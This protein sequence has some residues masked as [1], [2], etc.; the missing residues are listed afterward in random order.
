MPDHVN[1]YNDEDKKKWLR[2]RGWTVAL[3]PVPPGSPEGT[4]PTEMWRDPDRGVS[5]HFAMAMK[6]ALD[7]CRLPADFE[8]KPDV[9]RKAD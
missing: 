8:L 9:G 4:Q 2:Q 5:Y 6:K 3:R 7:E 1:T